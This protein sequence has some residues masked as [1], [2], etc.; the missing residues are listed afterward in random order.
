MTSQKRCAGCRVPACDGKHAPYNRAEADK[1]MP[2]GVAGLI[3]RHQDGRHVIHEPH[4]GQL[5]LPL[6]DRREV[7]RH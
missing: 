5:L 4:R 7:L 6:V 3:D 1:E 2:Q